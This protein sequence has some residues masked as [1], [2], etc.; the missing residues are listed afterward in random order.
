MG[1]LSTGWTFRTSLLHAGRQG[2]ISHTPS[3]PSPPHPA[4]EH[5]HFRG[6]PAGHHHVAG[7]HAHQALPH[8]P[9]TAVVRA[10]RD[11]G[12]PSGRRG[13][14]VTFKLTVYGR[15]ARQGKAAGCGAGHLGRSPLPVARARGAG[16]QAVRRAL[17]GHLLRQR[18]RAHARLGV[19]GA[20]GAERQEAG[21]RA[22]AGQ[23]PVRGAARSWR[24]RQPL[25]TS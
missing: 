13:G 12:E 6:G 4:A 7:Q 19:G 20:A 9:A 5:G 25:F 21:R 2:A 10:G 22:V 17:E 3:A 24:C 11:A 1:V 15:A 23:L 8:G 18:R 16:A 14:H